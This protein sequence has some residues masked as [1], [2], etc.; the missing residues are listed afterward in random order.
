MVRNKDLNWT[1]STQSPLLPKPNFIPDF[2]T[3]PTNISWKMGKEGY[4]QYH[5]SLFMLSACSNVA[6]SHGL[7]SL[8]INIFQCLSS[9]ACSL[10]QKTFLYG[11][12]SMS[13]RFYKAQHHS[14]M[15]FPMCC[16]VDIC[17]DLFSSMGWRSLFLLSLNR[18]PI[19]SVLML[20]WFQAPTQAA[21]SP[22][23]TVGQGEKI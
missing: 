18:M 17:Y 3:S 19:C 8:M 16:C 7:Q 14:G 1:F 2:S 4:C 23:F 21:P 15:G 11:P 22:P 6:S 13:P 10:C 5:S 12:L 9:M 20:V